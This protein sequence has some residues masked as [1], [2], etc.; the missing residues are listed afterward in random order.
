METRKNLSMKKSSPICFVA[1]CSGGHILPCLTLAKKLCEK[2]PTQQILFFS[3]NRP[4]DMQIIKQF[5]Q[6]QQVQQ[7][8]QPNH[9]GSIHTPTKSHAHF[10]HR[11]LHL[12]AISYRSYRK[13]YMFPF[14][15]WQLTHSFFSSFFHLLKHKPAKVISTGSHIAIPV[16]LA[17]WCLRIPIELFEVNVTPGKTVQFLAPLA[18]KISICFN[19]TK[20]YLSAY[21]HKCALANYPVKFNIHDKKLSQKEACKKLNLC[22]T[23]KT[24]LVLGGSQGS[25]FLNQTIKNLIQT[26]TNKAL[27]T[28]RNTCNK[29]MQVIHQ[30]GTLDQ[31]DWQKFYAKHDIP[32]IVFAYQERMAN[33]YAAADLV[34]C[35]AG[36]G[37]LAEVIFFEKKCITIPLETKAT[38]HQVDNAHAAVKQYPNFMQIVRQ[39]SIKKIYA[40]LSKALD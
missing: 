28:S 25:L 8:Q 27:N 36:A 26:N 1:G 4:L 29:N 30:T 2:N 14:I 33:Y 24:I 13:F 3:T 12:S 23:K 6:N 35:R 40:T 34:I 17:A 38:A 19:K 16:C 32:A 21:A 20:N 39:Q 22:P 37:T 7:A 15:A 5:Q 10:Y 18:Q 9:T 31:T 11:A